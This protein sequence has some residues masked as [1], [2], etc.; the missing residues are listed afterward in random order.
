MYVYYCPICGGI[1]RR[2]KSTY[3]CRDCQST[4]PD[5]KSE[6]EID[7]YEQKSVTLYDTSKYWN[8][9]L[10]EEEI[11]QGPLYDETKLPQDALLRLDK[12]YKE[13]QQII[14]KQEKRRQNW[15][16]GAYG[17]PTL[18]NCP[19]CNSSN[20][21]KVSEINSMGIMAG[22]FTVAGMGKQYECNNCGMK[23]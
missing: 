8:Y 23:F 18:P 15:A 6:H 4:V 2:D 1:N 9:L 10:L 14:E 7:Y 20:V 5:A 3:I 11:K 19:F 17:Y 12:Q 21:K 22:G 13:I 16:Y